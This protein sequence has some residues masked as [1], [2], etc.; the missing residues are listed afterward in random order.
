MFLPEA[1][2]LAET[3]HLVVEKA[4]NLLRS[5]RVRC[6]RKLIYQLQ[7]MLTCCGDDVLVFFLFVPFVY[8][9]YTSEAETEFLSKHCV[10]LFRE[11]SRHF[12]CSCAIA[13]HW[14]L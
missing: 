13:H 6:F 12:S 11:L 4:G 10:N 2:Q 9:S 5:R 3:P 7:Q 8:V 1:T 14:Q